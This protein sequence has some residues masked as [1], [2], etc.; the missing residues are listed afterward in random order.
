MLIPFHQKIDLPQFLRLRS[1]FVSIK[2]VRVLVV[3]VV[4]HSG[5]IIALTLEYGGR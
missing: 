1:V 3:H 4:V 5:C 2:G